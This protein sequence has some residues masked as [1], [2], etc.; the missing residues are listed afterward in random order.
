MKLIADE[1]SGAYQ[2][3]ITHIRKNEETCALEWYPI[4]F[5]DCTTPHFAQSVFESGAIN[6]FSILSHT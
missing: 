6:E 3:K 1:D 2:S 4:D 5:F